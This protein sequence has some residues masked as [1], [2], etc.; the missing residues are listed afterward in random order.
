[1]TNIEKPILQERIDRLADEELADNFERENEIDFSKFNEDRMKDGR[2]FKIFEDVA[3]FVKNKEKAIDIG[4]G[5]LRETKYLVDQGFKKVVVVDYSKL[6]ENYLKDIENKDAI[7]YFQEKVENYKFLQEDSDLIVSMNTLS[8][9]HKE[10]LS[11]VVQ[12][13][14]NA[15]KS[16]GVFV[17]TFFAVDDDLVKNGTSDGDKAS[18][19]NRKEIEELFKDFEFIEIGTIENGIDEYDEN[20]KIKN[21]T[22]VH[23]HDFLVIVQKK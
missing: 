17:G 13:I 15:L 3:E 1:M 18:G 20:I 16:E 8:W 11:D 7:E 6:N 23:K 9:V 2:H 22:M 21:G 4:A 10:R 14:K 19:L 5:A 12:N